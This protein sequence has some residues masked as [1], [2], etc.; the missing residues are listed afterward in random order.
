L[1]EYYVFEITTHHSQMIGGGGGEAEHDRL[2]TVLTNNVQ[3]IQYN[4]N[5]LNK[6][7][8]QLGTDKDTQEHRNKL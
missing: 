7:V 1:I 5:R 8:Q 4:V 2:L 6:M 3:Q